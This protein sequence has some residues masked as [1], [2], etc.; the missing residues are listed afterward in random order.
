MT[1]NLRRTARHC[2]SAF[3]AA[4]ATACL[5]DRAVAPGPNDD[6]SPSVRLGL[7]AT[8][9]GAAAGQTVRI[10]AYYVRVDGTHVPLVNTPTAVSV[11]PGVPQQVAV[12]VRIGPCLADPQHATGTSNGCEVGIDLAL[13]EDGTIIDEQSSPPTPSL[14]PGTTTTVPPITFTRVAQVTLGGT[15]VLRQ[16]ESR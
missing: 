6:G 2:A 13:E 11:T 9:I 16:G 12:L 15:A 4:L 5:N 3:L 8:I 10:S 1:T 7:H 14:R